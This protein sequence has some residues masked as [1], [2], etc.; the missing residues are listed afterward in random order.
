MLSR[1]NAAHHLEL[2]KQHLLGV[3]GA[4]L[5]DKPLPYKGGK[6]KHF[7]RAESS[8]FFGR[9]IGLMYTHA[10]LR[11]AQALAH[12]GEAQMFFDALSLVNPISVKNLVTSASLRQSN[13]YH[14][15]SDAKFSDRYQAFIEYDK[16]YSGEVEFE[17]GWR[18]YSS[19]GGIYSGL[20]ISTFL[21][22]RIRNDHLVID[23]VISKPLDGL[24]VRLNWEGQPL[25]I[26]YHIE[27]KGYG[28]TRILLNNE[29]LKF[30]EE[31]NPYRKGGAK[32]ILSAL[33]RNLGIENR[34]D[35]FL[36]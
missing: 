15:S 11:Y 3:D 26:C 25:E 13:C 19:G 33:R 5:F 16:V 35:V 12:L 29:Q 2:I 10:H 9:E 28:P 32:I 23:P 36:G 6:Q 31:S 24:E 4:R 1:E 17:G 22:L 8:S 14:S 20:V 21:G 34:L 27:T 7:Q 30:E 18:V